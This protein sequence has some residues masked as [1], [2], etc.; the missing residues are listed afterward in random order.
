[1]GVE[2]AG[3]QLLP[4]QRAIE[5]ASQPFAAEEPDKTFTAH[6]TLARIKSLSRQ[7]AGALAMV[8]NGLAEQVFGTWT[9]TAVDIMRSELSQ[10]GAKHTVLATVRLEERAATGKR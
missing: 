2:D 4:L 10:S 6:I 3:R 8:A 7:H 9:A 5:T 1:V